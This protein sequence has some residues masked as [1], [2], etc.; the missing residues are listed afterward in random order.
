MYEKL[1]NFR[2]IHP[3]A[4]SLVL[5]DAQNS[6]K[7][8]HEISRFGDIARK[9]EGGGG[10]KLAPGLYRVKLVQVMHVFSINTLFALYDHNTR[11]L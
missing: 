6:N 7:N 5:K 1:R 2:T 10:A 9:V 11:S 8:C 4:V 3:G